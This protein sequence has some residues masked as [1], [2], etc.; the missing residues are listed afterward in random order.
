MSERFFVPD[1]SAMLALGKRLAREAKPGDLIYLQG[2]LGAGKTTITRGFLKALGITYS[3]KSP[4]FTLVEVYELDDFYVFHFDLY[5]ITDPKEL[6]QIGLS[7]Y[8]TED[9]ICLIEWPE[10]AAGYLPEPT[11]YCTIEI[12]ENSEGRWVTLK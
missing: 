9:A 6:S 12:P 7:D 3:V 1:E 2:D 5:R 4:T 8:L 10:K 11:Q